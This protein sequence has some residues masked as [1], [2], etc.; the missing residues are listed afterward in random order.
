MWVSS[1]LVGALLCIRSATSVPLDIDDK[2][3]ICNAAAAIVQG[4][5]NYY[6]GFNHGGVIGKFVPPYYWWQAGAAFGGMLAFHAICEPTNTTLEDL[7][8]TAMY[9]QAGSQYNYMPANESFVEGNDDQGIWGLTTMEAVERN[10]TNHPDHSWLQLTQA[11]YN[12]MNSRWDPATCNGGIRWQ[13]FKWNS[14]YDYKNSIANGCLFHIAARLA[15]Y[16]GN[17]TYVETAERVWDWM[18]DVGFITYHPEDGQ[19]IVYDGGL[20]QSNCSSLT[21]IKWSYNY[22]VFMAGCA[23]MYNHTEDYK[24][25][26]RAEEILRAGDWFFNQSVM[27]EPSCQPGYRCNNDQR[28]FRALWSRSLSLTSIMAPGLYDD[29]RPY[30]EASAKGAAESCLGGRDGVTCGINWSLGAYDDNY[31]LGEQISAL[32]IIMA[33]F[34][35]SEVPPYT[36]TNGGSAVSD[37]E[38]GLDSR[39]ETNRKVL[40]IRNRDKAGAGFLT[41]LVLL[42]ILGMA[43]W[44]IL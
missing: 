19:L 17:D 33:L 34:A 31:G 7:L 32:E 13:I 6:D 43:I 27:Y 20:V 40:D 11:I 5:W 38:A 28:S 18:T 14:G 37:P 44:M 26:E 3:S 41:A 25:Y 24:W 4:Q 1:Y 35:R 16:T 42:A 12:T 10:F 29:I 2:D 30:I 36:S 15:R 8:Y 21:K 39:A 9:H 23:Y 22:G